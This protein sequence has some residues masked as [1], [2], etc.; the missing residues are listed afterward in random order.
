MPRVLREFPLGIRNA[1]KIEGV[2]LFGV[3]QLPIYLIWQHVNDTMLTTATLRKHDSGFFMPAIGLRE[4]GKVGGGT[5]YKV[6]QAV[7]GGLF[8]VM[9]C[10][11]TGQSMLP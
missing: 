11:L 7:M 2:E 8:T 10:W 9:V 1:L 6:R 4:L 5:V 3:Y